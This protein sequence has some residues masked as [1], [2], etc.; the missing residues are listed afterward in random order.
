MDFKK[1]LWNT[2]EKKAIGKIINIYDLIA[3]K[4]SDVKRKIIYH[5]KSCNNHDFK[6]VPHAGGNHDLHFCRKCGY[7]QELG[8][9][10]EQFKDKP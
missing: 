10:A 5:L 6:R 9:F 1:Y 3:C 7:N 8:F 2:D 4:Y